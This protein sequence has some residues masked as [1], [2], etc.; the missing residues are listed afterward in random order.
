M[1]W[2]DYLHKA[3]FRGAE[4]FVEDAEGGFG[5]RTAVHEYPL[6]DKPYVEDLGRR[7]R[8]IQLDA[9][10]LAT[11][12]NGFDYVP[13]RDALIRAT[14]E[15]GPGALVHP[16]LGELTVTLIEARLKES[17][18][19]GGLA[20]FRFTFIEAGEA[21]FPAATANTAALVEEK[22]DTAI[23][24]IEEDFSESFSVEDFPQFVS[25]E[26]ITQIGNGLAALDAAVR[27]LTTLPAGVAAY[28]TALSGVRDSLSSLI[29]SPLALA[30]R[31]THL[32]ADLNG[33]VE[34]P[35][36]ALQTLR[37]FFS[38][39]AA[40]SLYPA[41]SVPRST[42]SRTRQADNQAAVLA[43]YARAAV[44]ESVRAAAAMD[45]ASY[46]DAAAVRGELSGAIDTLLDAAGDPLFVAL[47]D[48]RVAMVRDITTRGANLA[49]VVSYRPGATLPALALAYDLY[50]DATRDQEIVTRNRISHP[51]FVPG[52]RALE[53]FADA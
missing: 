25:I 29:L 21:T 52:G 27:G 12:A 7:A 20:R 44:V 16:Y 31:I 17:T 9:Y 39:G 1:S 22:S 10:V 46:Q 19:E 4:F 34:A 18:G 49:R 28:M 5:R 48:L 36:A 32:V 38:F 14:E 2:R 11:A 41:L 40:D 33:L 50:G 51:G 24:A 13:A 53:V 35:A 8:E 42:P 43:L 45:Y 3:S 6:R 47:T 30:A 26:A 37:T 23:A 15:P